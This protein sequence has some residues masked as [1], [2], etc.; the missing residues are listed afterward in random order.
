VP[1][2]GVSL[3]RA[4]ESRSFSLIPPDRILQDTVE[5]SDRGTSLTRTNAVK[6]V[7]D[8][9]ICCRCLPNLHGRFRLAR[10]VFAGRDR[11]SVP[12]HSAASTLEVAY[13][14]YGFGLS[15]VPRPH[16]LPLDSQRLSRSLEL[17]PTA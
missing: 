16:G 10:G 3:N 5:E 6:M 1:H 13:W 15:P 9:H 4:S 7:P 14:G 8:L 11:R 17:S 12:S 2:F